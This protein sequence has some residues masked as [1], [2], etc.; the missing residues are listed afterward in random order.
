MPVAPVEV[1]G[2]NVADS[3]RLAGASARYRK[4]NHLYDEMRTAFGDGL[5]TS[6]DDT[7]LRQK[8]FLQPLFTHA[9]RNLGFA[10]LKLN[11]LR[12]FDYL[13]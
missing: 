7:W 1:S 6:Q 2:E 3:G 5:L 12:Q 13:V 10:R 11:R 9:Q 8:R 4:D